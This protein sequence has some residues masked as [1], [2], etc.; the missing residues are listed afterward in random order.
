MSCPSGLPIAALNLKGPVMAHDRVAQYRRWFDYEK[1]SHRRVL[2]SLADIPPD[3]HQSPSFQRALSIMAHIV[4]ARQVWLF[5]FGLI[6]DRPA[7]LFPTN[8]ALDE[9]P[10]RLEAMEHEW[11]GYFQSLTEEELDRGFEYQSLDAGRFRS[12]VED[13]LTQLFGHSLYHR[14]QIASLVKITGGQPA[15]TDFV[16]WSRKAVAASQ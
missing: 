5:R 3:Q 11:T 2:A 12:V 8:V 4:A 7:E 6:S 16:Y 1:D 10:E 15:V 14:G 9:L 13:I